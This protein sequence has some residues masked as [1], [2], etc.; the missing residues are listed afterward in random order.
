MNSM[1]GSQ[2]IPT[3]AEYKMHSFLVP[4]Y[5]SDGLVDF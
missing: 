4:P 2:M 5:V 3:Y 1:E